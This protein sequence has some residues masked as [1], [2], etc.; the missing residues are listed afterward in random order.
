MPSAFGE[1]EVK[2]SSSRS[3]CY[4][5]LLKI[6]VPQCSIYVKMGGK[7]ENEMRYCFEQFL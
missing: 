7:T 4:V 5:M 1:C 3:G 2:F 6:R